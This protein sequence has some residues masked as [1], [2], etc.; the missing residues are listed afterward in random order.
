MAKR[1]A[2]SAN[3]DKWGRK[4][5]PNGKMKPYPKIWGLRKPLGVDKK[6][7][8]MMYGK[9]VVPPLKKKAPPAK[10]PAARKK[11]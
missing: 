2:P 5:L 4:L 9:P 3:I 1:A 11:K 10:V 7:G 8:R 6:T